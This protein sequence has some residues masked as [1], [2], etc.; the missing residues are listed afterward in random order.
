MILV[1]GTSDTTRIL[2]TSTALARFSRVEHDNAIIEKKVDA[3]ERYPRA[4]S[5]AP[6]NFDDNERRGYLSNYLSASTL[7]QTDLP[8]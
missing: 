5:A 4:L 8:N 1:G 2:L 6:I 3:S 7:A